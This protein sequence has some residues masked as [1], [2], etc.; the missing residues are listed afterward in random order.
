MIRSAT[1]PT[2][3]IELGDLPI[4]SDDE[5]ALA[6]ALAD[7]QGAVTVMLRPDD[8]VHDDTSPVHATVVRKAFRGA[9]F[10]YTL[11]LPSGTTLLALV[12]SH[13]DHPVGESIGIRFDADHVV[14][15]ERQ[16]AG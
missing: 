13:H 9:Q 11:R 10:L 8:V 6:A 4:R 5:Q 2:I 12:P 3:R 14:T 16:S 1:G 7:D 15:F